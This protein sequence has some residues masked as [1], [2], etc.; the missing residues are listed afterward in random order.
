LSRE[1]SIKEGETMAKKPKYYVRPDGLHEAIRTINGKR[2]AFR[3]RTDAE[4]EKKMIEYRE[5][6]Q[7]GP[8]FK[9]VAEKWEEKHYPTLSP[10]TIRSYKPACRRACDRFEDMPIKDILPSDVA[11]LLQKMAAQQYARK[12]VATQLL[13]INL[14]C[15]HAVIEGDLRIN[16]CREVTVP[17]G[18]ARKPREIPTDAELNAVKQGLDLPGGMLPYFIL[19]TGCRR[20]EALAL[21]YKDIDFKKKIIHINKSLCH[22][23]GK[24]YLKAPKSKA[25]VRDVPLLDKLFKVLP[26]GIGLLFP[27]PDGGLMRE[28]DYLRVWRAWQKAAKVKVTA[29]QLRHGYATM[30]FES[31]IPE[32]D[33]MDLLGH[34]DIKLTQNIYT[35]IRKNRKQQTIAALNATAD[36]F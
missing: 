34:A 12:T 30:L 3:G 22:E 7:R 8:L 32:R 6:Q 31:G 18:L 5:H 27:G 35:H 25:G 4:V 28:A 2:V 20:G 26:R 13:V 23:D 15:R 1:F 14:I 36:I 11:A 33:A 19:Y 9:E 29:H 10:Y 17:Q 21:S 16:P 24:P